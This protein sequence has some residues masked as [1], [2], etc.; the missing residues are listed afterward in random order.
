MKD[1]H[2]GTRFYIVPPDIVPV[3]RTSPVRAR[4]RTPWRPQPDGMQAV[5]RTGGREWFGA[6]L[7]LEPERTHVPWALG[8]MVLVHV[9]VALTIGTAFIKQAQ[10]PVI[11]RAAQLHLTPV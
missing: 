4:K 1:P 8:A 2:F 5:D 9:V 7:T 3:R 10:P 6:H 11:A